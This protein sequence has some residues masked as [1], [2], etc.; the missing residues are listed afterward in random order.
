METFDI[1]KSAYVNA[2]VAYVSTNDKLESVMNCLK[3]DGTDALT[4]PFAK[5]LRNE[6][7]S[8][9]M[10]V[11]NAAKLMAG[12]LTNAATAQLVNEEYDGLFAASF[13]ADP[14]DACSCQFKFD[15]VIV[16]KRETWINQ[17]YE[18]DRLANTMRF[19]IVD[20]TDAERILDKYQI[21]HSKRYSTDWMS[22]NE[23]MDADPHDTI[24]ELV[25]LAEEGIV[26]YQSH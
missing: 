6:S 9:E 23:L 4:D 8:N 19:G 24:N 7:W 13:S 16:P 12:Y 20:I 5:E 15:V 25:H 14:S 26:H 17:Y 22:D 18:L 1:Y 10:D 3:K 2:K 21:L 11:N